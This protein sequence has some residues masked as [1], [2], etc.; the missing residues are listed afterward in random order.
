MVEKQSD[1]WDPTL[2]FC[3]ALAKKVSQTLKQSSVQQM[4]FQQSSMPQAA[5]SCVPLALQMFTAQI[6][7]PLLLSYHSLWGPDF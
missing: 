1:L 4:H 5:E 6:F 7:T 3:D 2:G